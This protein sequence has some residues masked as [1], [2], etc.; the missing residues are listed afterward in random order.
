MKQLFN[1]RG[2][3]RKQLT[4]GVL[5]LI[6]LL[7]SKCNK[8][9]P[10]KPTEPQNLE[11]ELRV[12]APSVT[13]EEGGY[14]IL[15]LILESKLSKDLI[16]KGE[17][18]KTGLVN[19]LDDSEYGN[20]FEYSNDGVNWSKEASADEIRFKKN[21]HLLK[22][23]IKINEDATPEAVEE[24]NLKLTIK[25]NSEFT[26]TNKLP[27]EI[28]LEVLYNDADE[29]LDS[30]LIDVAFENN[31]STYK[32]A[33]VKRV[34][35]KTKKYINP[36]I[37]TPAIE[38]AKKAY[39]LLP[40]TIKVGKLIFD[41][42]GQGGVVYPT[43][44]PK[45]EIWNMGIS[46][47]LAYINDQGQSTDNFNEIGLY[48]YIF[49][50]EMGHLFTLHRGEIDETSTN[51]ANYSNQEGCTKVNSAINEFNEGYYKDDPTLNEPTHVSDYA[52]GRLEED[53]AECFAHGIAQATIPTAT[54]ISSGA[55]QKLNFIKGRDFFQYKSK[56]KEIFG[57]I[58]F[59]PGQNDVMSRYSYKN[60]K[61]E[62]IPCTDYIEIK[63][64]QKRMNSKR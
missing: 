24:L 48:G 8:D 20:D 21:N 19:P 44:G 2:S 60:E 29:Y 39:E 58:I 49:T 59:P 3:V 5:L 40:S 4:W 47:D 34:T 41:A 57:K 53:I 33:I 27:S 32:L 28:K 9:E 50:H 56:L 42:N 63:K 6:P 30:G 15:D 1:V 13:G 62:I 12:E 54:N 25:N 52:K 35:Q 23:R 37:Y 38:A 7:F 55:L 22:V 31:Y 17:F 64:A 43:D 45:N 18:D 10:I 46:L 26:I 16:L 11:S 51:C 36:D 14:V 61:G